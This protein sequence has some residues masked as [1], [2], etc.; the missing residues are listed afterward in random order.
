MINATKGANLLTHIFKFITSKWGKWITLTTWLIGSIILIMAAPV[1]KESTQAT[2]WLPNSAESTKAFNISVEQFPQPGLPVIIV[3][4]NT[5]GLSASDYTQARNIDTWLKTNKE[6]L[7]LQNIVSLFNTPEARNELLS[8]DESTMTIIVNVSGTPTEDKFQ[9]SVQDIR[10]YVSQFRTD[11]LKL[12]TGGPAGMY[13][14]VITVF[15]QIDGLL[16]IVTILLVLVLLLLI[17]R[18][19]IVAIVPLLCVGLVMQVSLSIIAFISESSSFLVV[20]GQSRGVMTVVLFGSGTDYCLFIASR[21]KEEL[22]RSP[23]SLEAMRNTMRGIGGAVA[24]AGATIIIAS[25]I[26][27]IAD[28]KSYQSMGPV[29]GIAIV[30]MTVASLTLVPAIL[31]VLGPKAFWPFTPKVNTNT[32]S[33]QTTIYG[34]IGNIVLKKPIFTLLATSGVL[35]IFIF[36]IIG[37]EKSFDQLDSLPQNTESVRSFELL[38][39][40]FS[41]GLLSPTNVYIDIKE[42]NHLDSEVAAEL[43]LIALT[44]LEDELVLDVSYFGRPFGFNSKIDNKYVLEAYGT[45]FNELQPIIQRSQKFSSFNQN[46]LRYD[47]V[48]NINP[49]SNEALDFIPK[50]RNNLSE[51]LDNSSLIEPN[52]Y[53]GGETAEA[54]DTRTA[55]NRDTYLVLPL[56][57]LAIGI[58]LVILLKSLV[59]PLYLLMTII[60]TYFSTLGLSIFIFKNIFGQDTITP[61]LAFFLFIFLNALG[62]DY[63]IYLMSR[64]K[65]ESEKSHL[66]TAVLKTLALTGGVITSAGLILAGTFSALMSLPL[67][68]LFQLG[69]AVA[70]GVLMDTFITRTLIVPSLVKLLGKWNWW[71]T[72]QSQNLQF[73]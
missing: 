64:L 20:N 44:I 7:G 52:I 5:N 48:L 43:D 31:T 9:D 73:K 71:P 15:T 14:D 55:A 56:I 27:L 49:Y 67:Q 28:L 13:L 21:F 32:E 36:G 66:D 39:Q 41:P 1:L 61:G 38:R 18:S 16:L 34:R 50:L 59:A 8:P 19:P 46:M 30:I 37:S 22:K 45:N 63:N 68:D 4:R 2:D 51:A 62:V 54:Y 25:A 53:V 12:E 17:Y 26:L 11:R 40:G 65:E 33:E 60:F 58:V 23:S 10:D 69:F 72:R 24:S 35:G 29:I 57:L 3:I 6:N 70:I 42:Q 47:V